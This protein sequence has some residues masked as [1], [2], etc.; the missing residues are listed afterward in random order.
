MHDE[1]D[2]FRRRMQ[3]TAEIDRVPGGPRAQ[4]RYAREKAERERSEVWERLADTLDAI[5]GN[6]A[7]SDADE[8]APRI[9][10]PAN[11]NARYRRNGYVCRGNHDGK[12]RFS[13][14]QVNGKNE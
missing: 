10:Y 1:L 9:L 8:A 2:A 5:A 12:V 11:D 4:A 13:N 3:E 6:G 7:G 14:K